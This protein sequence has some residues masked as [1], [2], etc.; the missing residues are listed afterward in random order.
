[1]NLGKVEVKVFLVSHSSG[2]FNSLEYFI[3]VKIFRNK[4]NAKKFIKQQRDPGTWRIDTV[5]FVF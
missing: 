1:M 3:P 5:P 2:H 4:E